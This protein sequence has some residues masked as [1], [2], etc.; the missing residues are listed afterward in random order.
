MAGNFFDEPFDDETKVKLNIYRAY[1]R[2]WLPVWIKNK[3]LDINVFD[4]FAG[5]G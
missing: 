3:S 1:L 2:E 5:R 4:F